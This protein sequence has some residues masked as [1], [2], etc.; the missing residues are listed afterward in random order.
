MFVAC[1]RDMIEAGSFVGVDFGEDI[2]VTHTFGFRDPIDERFETLDFECFPINKC[3]LPR[4]VVI[5]FLAYVPR[6]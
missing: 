3:D 2:L 5:V 6:G 4:L 1:L